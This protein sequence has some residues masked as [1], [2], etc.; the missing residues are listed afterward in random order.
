MNKLE[1]SNL[2][3]FLQRR[4]AVRLG[5]RYAIA[6]AGVIILGFIPI[7]HEKAS[8]SGVK[9]YDEKGSGRGELIN[10]F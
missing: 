9:W 6:A 3:A 5:R 10:P 8:L 1:F 2:R 7:H 4:Y